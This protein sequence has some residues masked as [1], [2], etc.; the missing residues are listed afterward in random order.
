MTSRA[1]LL[2]VALFTGA[3][4][5]GCQSAAPQRPAQTSPLADLRAPYLQAE[6]T[7]GEVYTLDPAASTIRL[8]VFRGGKAA[9]AGHN[10]VLG[11]SDFEGYVMLDPDQPSA[12]RFDLR[13]R[14][15]ALKVDDPA[16]RDQTGGNFASKR[17]ESDIEGT[18]RNLLGPK[19][20]GAAEFP[21][22]ELRSQA[23]AGDWPVLI[24]DVIITI[25]GAT[26]VQPVIIHVERDAGGLRVSGEFVMRQTDYGIEPFSV[27]GGL[28][29]VQDGVGVTF[30][31][32]GRP[33]LAR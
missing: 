14:A 29:A 3:T 27:L 20:L 31:L 18:R 4:L 24:A 7:R 2:A 8:F 23:V 32:K 25:K 1:R 9:K 30:K 13:V 19:V 5:A 17:S 16:W 21:T 33:G 6:A 15:D 11:V 10:H 26:H 12:S 28:M 22:I